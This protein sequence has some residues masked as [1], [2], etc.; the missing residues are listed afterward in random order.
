VSSRPGISYLT[1]KAA[2]A[3]AADGTAASPTRIHVS[4]RCVG[5]P[6]LILQRSNLVIE[7]DPPSGACPRLG[8]E[9][10]TLTSSLISDRSTP[11][12][13]SHG[14]IVKVLSSTNIA[15]RFLNLVNNDPEDAVE[16]K[17]SSSGD[18]TCNCC[19]GN[20]ECF[21]MS[22][23]KGY[24]V[25]QNLVTDNG[26]GINAGH[27]ARN[28]TIMNNT[29]V[30][31]RRVF[32][33]DVEQGDGITILEGTT[34][35]S[36]VGNIVRD[37]LDDGI[38]LEDASSITVTDNVV[39]GNGFT[40]AGVPTAGGF[41]IVLQNSSNNLIDCNTISGNADGLTDQARVLS[42]TGNTGSNVSGSACVR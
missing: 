2:L 40:D 12:T 19:S 1:L 3:A 7:G 32:E 35:T 23:G 33:T 18:M 38:D 41:G 39:T 34:A 27:L 13:G 9:P 17:K 22:G 30:S 16:Y 24:V 11:P 42:G 31:N 6:V 26:H 4:G 8:P 25:K 37:N 21:E 14:E 36:V 28:V 15:I 5:P 29:I 20:E 10:K